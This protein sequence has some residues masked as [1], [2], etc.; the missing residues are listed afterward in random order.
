MLLY[1]SAA[2]KAFLAL[3]VAVNAYVRAIGGVEPASRSERRRL[4]GKMGGED[5]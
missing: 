4:L 2:D 1:R 3:V 5:L